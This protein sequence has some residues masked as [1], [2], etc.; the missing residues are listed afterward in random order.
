MEAHLIVTEQ[1]TS[2]ESLKVRL[3]SIVG[4]SASLTA[5]GEDMKYHLSSLVSH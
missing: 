4:F 5:V 3:T 2:D 1:E